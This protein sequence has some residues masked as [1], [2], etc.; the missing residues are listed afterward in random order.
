MPDIPSRH[1]ITHDA[2]HAW[3]WSGHVLHTTSFRWPIVL[4]SLLVVPFLLAAYAIRERRRKGAVSRFGNPALMPNLVSRRPRWRRHIIPII[5]LLALTALLV[6]AARPER[7]VIADKR[8]ATIVLAIDTSRSMSATDVKPNRLTAARGAARTLVASLP[9][10]GRVGVVAFTR[11]VHVL[12]TPTDD[13]SVIRGSLNALTIGGGTA[14]GDALAQSLKLVKEDNAKKT[15]T[16]ERPAA[17]I[18]VLSDGSSTEGK[19]GPLAAAKQ[20]KSANVPVYTVALGTSGGTIKDPATGGTV[21]VAPDPA[22]L[23]AIA[24][25]GGGQS[26]TA[27]NAGQLRTIYAGIGK[28]VGTEQKEQDLGF[29]FVG[30]ATLLMLGSTGLSLRWF[31]RAI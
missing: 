16:D 31:R 12:N 20:A 27:K 28:K 22:S 26:Y 21:S 17:A 25:A 24:K 23:A 11:S 14:I 3:H 5:M 18:V 7:S 19:I 15:A 30:L 10:D 1:E 8:Q 6:G 9:D 4:A 13:R 29:G 2:W